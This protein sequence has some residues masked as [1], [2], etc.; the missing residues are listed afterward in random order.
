MAPAKDRLGPTLPDFRAAAKFTIMTRLTP[1]QLM[2]SM[3]TASLDIAIYARKLHVHAGTCLQLTLHYWKQHR[4]QQ[5][6][7]FACR[8]MLHPAER[9]QRVVCSA[10]PWL[11]CSSKA[12]CGGRRRSARYG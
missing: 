7:L 5:L 9:Y 2:V 12:K 4:M 11:S 10:S 6:C 3:C 1:F 8:C